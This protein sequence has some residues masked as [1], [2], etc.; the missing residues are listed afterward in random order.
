MEKKN[1]SNT[2][3]YFVLFI[4]II[5]LIIFIGKYFS[6]KIK[7]NFN[8]WMNDNNFAPYNNP[9]AEKGKIQDNIYLDSRL[10]KFEKPNI[11]NNGYI[12][13]GWPPANPL[14]NYPTLNF[15]PMITPNQEKK[16]V[17][18][19]PFQKNYKVGIMGGV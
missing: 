8:N 7:E 17:Y 14:Y 4:V 15:H 16:V 18:G 19:D 2:L 13:M 9:N 1:K 11:C 10:N 6:P 12:N 3:I 5:L